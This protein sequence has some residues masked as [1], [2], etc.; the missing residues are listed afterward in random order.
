M[1][2]NYIQERTLAARGIDKKY[3]MREYVIEMPCPICGDVIASILE[4]DAWNELDKHSEIHLKHRFYQVYGEHMLS[5]Y[6]KIKDNPYKYMKQEPM[7]LPLYP[8]DICQNMTI[9]DRIK[10]VFNR[11]HRG[12][13]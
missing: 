1:K 6:D 2:P 5:H 8:Y 13:K 7:P 4:L 11:K 9:L 12:K 10:F 3:Q